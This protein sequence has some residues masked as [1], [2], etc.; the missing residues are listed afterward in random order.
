M[1]AKYPLTASWAAFRSDSTVG[2]QDD[3]CVD[4]MV[5]SELEEHDNRR[6]F[7]AG[8]S[9]ASSPLV[10]ESQLNKSQLNESQLSLISWR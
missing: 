1:A 2:R 8:D 9:C 10:H 3:W 7:E 4:D 5:V 6:W